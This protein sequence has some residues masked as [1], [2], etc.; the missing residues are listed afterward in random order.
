[1]GPVLRCEPADG[2]P[3]RHAGRAGDRPRGPD[4]HHPRPRAAPREVAPRVLR[5]GSGAG[6]RSPRRPA[7]GRARGLSGSA[8]TRWA[9]SS[10]SR[11]STSLPPADRYVGDE[12]VTEGWAFLFQYLLADP[13]WLAGELR[14]PRDAI[15]GWLDFGAFRKLYF[16]RR[17][18]GQAPLRAPPAPRRGSGGAARRVRRPAGPPHRHPHPGRELPG[19]CRRRAV[20]RALPPGLAV[21]GQRVLRPA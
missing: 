17:Y 16:L 9:T 20:C 15:A 21:R 13:E 14:M 18:G 1:M 11:T 7:A 2:G 10:I 19:G 5:P 8:L 3:D 6:R 12:T 4:G